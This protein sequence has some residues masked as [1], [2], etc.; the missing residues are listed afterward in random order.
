MR[1]GQVLDRGVLSV[2]DNQV[3]P[4]TGTIKL[5]ATF[6]NKDGSLWPGGFVGMQL[7]VD[8]AH[9]ALVVPPAAIQRGP[10]GPYVFVATGGAVKRQPVTLGHEDE[11]WSIVTEGLGVGDKVVIDG[12]SRLSDGTKIS[13]VQPTAAEVQNEAVR[14]SAPGTRH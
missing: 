10:S 3:D 6:P 8:T 11:Q 7:Q 13:V 5:K 9:N 14:P 2:L 12:A 1:R 4:T